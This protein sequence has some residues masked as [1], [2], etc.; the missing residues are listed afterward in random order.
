MIQLQSV[1]KDLF[2]DTK[3]PLHKSTAVLVYLLFSL[4]SVIVNLTVVGRIVQLERICF[5]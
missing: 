3:K 1:R 4:S 2:T 5:S